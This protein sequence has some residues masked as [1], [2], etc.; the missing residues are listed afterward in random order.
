MANK[1][2]FRKKDGSRCRA[3]A[4]PANGLCV[5]HDP[6]RIIDGHRARR[7]G[8]LTRARPAAVLAP[9]TPDHPLGNMRDVA[10]LLSLSINQLRRGQLDP[11]VANAMGYLASVL[12]KTLEIGR[13][14]D[15]LAHLETVITGQTGNEIDVFDFQ[16]KN[17][18]GGDGQPSTASE[19]D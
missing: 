18:G 8:G 16:A 13:M 17:P 14:E 19:K 4:Q 10:L 2:E 6:A 1:C 5:F 7:A 11:R 15:R 3:N 12:L 9:D